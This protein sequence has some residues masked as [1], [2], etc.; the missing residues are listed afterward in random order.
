METN[1]K[2]VRGYPLLPT[3][4]CAFCSRTKCRYAIYTVDLQFVE[5]ACR[6][7]QAELEA[8]ADQLLGA[9]S[10]KHLSKQRI[11][12]RAIKER[13]TE[14]IMRLVAIVTSP[15]CQLEGEAIAQAFLAIDMS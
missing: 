4:Q 7:H 15:A 12:R 9:K 5:I 2:T 14:K 1:I 13:I 6:S 8:M 10:R 11:T 3:N